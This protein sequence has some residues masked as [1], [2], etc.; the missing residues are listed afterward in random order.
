M[1]LPLEDKVWTY[2][3]YRE[4]PDDGIRYEVIEGRLYLTPAPT[5]YHQTLSRR[6]QFVFYQLE[7]EGKGQIYDAPVD[8]LMEGA[9][10]VQPDLV[11]LRADQASLVTRR[12]IEGVPELLVEILSPSTATRDRTLKL[13]RYARCGVRRYGVLDPA[14]R[15]FELLRLD[16]ETYRLEAALGPH[17]VFDLSDYGVT[18]DMNA[19]FQGLPDDL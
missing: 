17:D 8:V 14:S 10:P 11:Y 13:N 3:D 5:P 12:G 15:T 9:T 1:T 6:L 18:I 16:G 7:L 19:L 2:E 4:L